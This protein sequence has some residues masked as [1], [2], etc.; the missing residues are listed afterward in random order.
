MALTVRIGMDWQDG[1]ASVDIGEVA[2]LLAVI[3]QTGTVRAAAAA[4]DM[5]YRTAWGRLEAA[6][7]ALGF[8]LVTKSKGHGSALTG[9]GEQLCR[10]VDEFEENLRSRVAREKKNFEERFRLAVRPAPLRLRLACSYDMLLNDCGQLGELP[11]WDIRF[12][13]SRKAMDAMRGG[14]ADLAGFHVAGMAS[15]EAMPSSLLPDKDCFMQTLMRREQGLVVAKGNPLGIRGIDDL[16]RP[17]VRFI[18]RQ[19]NADTRQWFDRL[20]AA[21]GIAP[22]AIRGYEHEEFTHSA[23]AMAVAAGAADAG[24]A[25]KAATE[26]L[27]VDFITIG[28]ESYF[29]CGRQDLLVDPRY[30]A[31][32]NRMVTHAA[33]RGGYALP[34][35]QAV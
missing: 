34:E 7:G 32:V 31:L 26:G 6:E 10:L 3:G 33:S 30:L 27:A 20:I 11:D 24:F 28:F 15:G 14:A 16:I 22:A 4:L 2:R 13:G 35:P 1:V 19:K 5:S 18:N 25:L 17:G 21:R 9:P 29:L 8:K 12:M 23:V